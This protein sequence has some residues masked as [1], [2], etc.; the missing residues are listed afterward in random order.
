MSDTPNFDRITNQQNDTPIFNN[1][2]NPGDESEENP[3]TVPNKWIPSMKVRMW[4]YGILVALAAL[5][6][7]YGLITIAEGGLWLA[8]GAAI[9]GIGH[10]LAARNSI[11]PKE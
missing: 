1:I 6:V 11:P 7:F 9:L 8:L 2:E 5:G 10:L 3:N 4:I